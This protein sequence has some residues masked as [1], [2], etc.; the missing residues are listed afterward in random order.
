[1]SR[2]PELTHARRDHGEML[3]Y[4]CYGA[5]CGAVAVRSLVLAQGPL[6]HTVDDFWRLIWTHYVKHIVMCARVV[7]AG[8]VR[9]LITCVFNQLLQQKCAKYWPDVGFTAQSGGIK[10]V[11]IAV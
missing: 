6:P 2:T 8:R 10:I 1:M 4:R 7:E 9:G 11:N 3:S 5:V